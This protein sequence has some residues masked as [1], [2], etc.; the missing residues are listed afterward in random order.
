MANVERIAAELIASE[1]KIYKGVSA[2]FGLNKCK[3]FSAV[4]SFGSG[5]C[6]IKLPPLCAC[7]YA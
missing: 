1:R 2:L 3:I 6:I 5:S 4:E 7:K